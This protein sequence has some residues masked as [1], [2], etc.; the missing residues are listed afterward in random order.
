MKALAVPLLAVLT[1][2]ATDL[3]NQRHAQHGADQIKIV[4][5]QR[6]AQLQERQA[7][8]RMNVALVEA[9]ARVAEANPEQAPSVSVALAVIGVKSASMEA[10]D[11][12]TV[13]LQQEQNVGL[14]YVKA[15]APTVG[16]LVTG[17]GIAALNAEVQKNASDN[18]RDILLGDQAADRG[19]VEAVAGLGSTAVANSGMSVGGSYYDL[20]DQAVV[21]QSQYTSM[22]TTT[23]NTTET[24]L[25]TGTTYDG[26][27]DGFIVN[28]NYDYQFLDDGATVTYGGAE[29]NLGSII[30]YLQGLGQPYSLTLDGEVY[31]SS[32]EGEGETITID[33]SKPQFSPAPP[34]CS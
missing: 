18:N 6:E 14:E 9:L 30:Q 4:A 33:C 1:G 12:P 20:Q 29:T 13:T 16:N 10:F 32:Q 28:G 15:L 26:S 3:G 19:I 23:T 24:S 21:D 27:D 22:D 2:C 5:V 7:E 17:L 31:S 8:A 34:E 11:A 25:D